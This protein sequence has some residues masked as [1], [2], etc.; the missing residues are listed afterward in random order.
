MERRLK[1]RERESKLWVGGSHVGT[2]SQGGRRQSG[3]GKGK[4]GVKGAPATKKKQME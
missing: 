3:K 4:G 2:A 1:R